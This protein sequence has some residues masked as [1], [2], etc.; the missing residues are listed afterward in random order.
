[1]RTRVSSHSTH[2]AEADFEDSFESS[3]CQ[4]DCNVLC[5]WFSVIY[6]SSFAYAALWPFKPS[7]CYINESCQNG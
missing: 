6:Y 2:S 1:M 7:V 5:V 4:T 3:A